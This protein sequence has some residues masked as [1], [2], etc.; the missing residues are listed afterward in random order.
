MKVMITGASGFL[1]RAVVPELLAQGVEVL[2]VSTRPERVMEMWPIQAVDL[3]ES[4]M[5][6]TS[7]ELERFTDAYLLHLGWLGLP[8]YSPGNCARNVAVSSAVF[9]FALSRGVRRIVGAGSC[10]EYGNHTGQLTEEKHPE[11]ISIFAQAKLDVLARLHTLHE[12]LDFDYRWA[13]IFYAYGKGQRET[14]LIPL[15]ASAW[16]RGQQPELRDPK[17][18]IDLIHVS[19]VARALVTLVLADG[20]SGTF[21]VG[22][23]TP[24]KAETVVE[25]VKHRL[26]GDP[27][28]LSV[29]LDDATSAAWADIRAI[30]STFGWH[31]RI[32]IEE[33]IALAV[34]CRVP[35]ERPIE[36]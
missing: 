35:H 12:E 20:P 30:S 31:P 10:W 24:V 9:S 26:L 18:A 21:N 29:G 6:H 3:N 11:T 33:G 32:A 16:R 1:G 4:L 2:A 25:L 13:R 17:Q 19:D 5:G 27:Q 7:E 15:A 22:S 14:S 28:P 34:D 8:D 36:R 23:G